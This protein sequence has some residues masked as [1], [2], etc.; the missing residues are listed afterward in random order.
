MNWGY[1]IVFAYVGFVALIV[2]LVVM[3]MRENSDLVTKDYYAKELNFQSD[4]NSQQNAKN[5][6]SELKC[7]VDAERIT[8]QFPSEFINE[9]MEG[10]IYFYK[11]SN[12]KAD[13]LIPINATNGQQYIPISN[14][15]EK[16]M[17]KTIVN[18]KSNNISYQVERTITIL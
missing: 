7:S 12:A 13:I 9:K 6:K 17:Y 14:M 5:L 4:I 8:I 2:I 16:G 11:P 15:K 18:W 3:S 10:S 1:K